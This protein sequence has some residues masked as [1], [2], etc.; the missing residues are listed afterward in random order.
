M[1][2]PDADN[3]GQRPVRVFVVD[4]HAVVRR[5]LQAYLE[6]VDD[7]EVVGEA[8]DGQAALD[9]IAALVAAGRPADVVLMDLIMPGVDGVTATAAITSRRAQLGTCSR[10]PRPTWSARQ[11][12]PP[13]GA[14]SIWT[15]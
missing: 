4:D 3:P 14:R 11:S 8:A 13:V 15:R 7:M 6:M 5:G 10:T 9:G 2:R 12:G 1:S